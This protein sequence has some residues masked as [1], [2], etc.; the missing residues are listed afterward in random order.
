MVD[1]KDNYKFDLG[2]TGLS[3]RELKHTTNNGACQTSFFF[4]LNFFLG[5]IRGS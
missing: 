3:A 1:T 2:V 5:R 4:F